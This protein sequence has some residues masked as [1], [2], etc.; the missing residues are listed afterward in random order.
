MLLRD[1]SIQSIAVLYLVIVVGCIYF[2]F[3]LGGIMGSELLALDPG[4]QVA[5]LGGVFFY[6]R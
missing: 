5:V 3:S 1:R 2:G 4:L 6:S